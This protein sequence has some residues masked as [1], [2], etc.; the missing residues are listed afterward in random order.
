MGF[1]CLLNLFRRVFRPLLPP[2]VVASFI[3]AIGINMNTIKLHTTKFQGAGNYE[4]F[5][6]AAKKLNFVGG[7]TFAWFFRTEIGW[8]SFT[9]TS[10]A[11]AIAAL[12]RK[13]GFDIY[14]EVC[15]TVQ[16]D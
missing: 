6:K 9:D 1:S 15:G 10:K 4:A 11:E 13:F 3:N 2:N 7:I 5:K 16:I 14:S 12:A 8:A